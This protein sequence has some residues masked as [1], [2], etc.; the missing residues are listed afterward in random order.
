MRI[1][2]KKILCPVDFSDCSEH[3]M[4]YAMAFAEA[5]GSQLELLHVV[6]MPFLPSYSTAGI[7]EI[8]FPLDE[9]KKQSRERLDKLVE[10]CG[11]ERYKISGNVVVGAP[12]LEV[13]KVAKEGE[14]DLIV[15][16][17]HGR[18]GLK[19]MLIGSVA[20]KIVRKAPCPVLTVKHPEHEFV[21]P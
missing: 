20:E 8:H 18:S 17:T 19:Q 3:A 5:Y 16:G 6:E 7:P 12:F 15:I 14:F 1:E 9:I 4:R 21:M 11:N 2:I 13:V 10:E